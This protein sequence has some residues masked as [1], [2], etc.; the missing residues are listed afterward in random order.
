MG[1]TT[2]G[3]PNTPAAPGSLN[4]GPQPVNGSTSGAPGLHRPMAAPNTDVLQD[5]NVM[6]SGARDVDPVTPDEKARPTQRSSSSIE[7]Q[8]DRF[9]EELLGIF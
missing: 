8:A 4:F 3:M 9:E 6:D 1:N 2:S 7:Q 5:S